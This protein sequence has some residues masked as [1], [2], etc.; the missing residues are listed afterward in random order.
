[1]SQFQQVGEGDN[2]GERRETEAVFR[3][4]V[5]QE[6]PR[7]LLVRQ[8]PARLPR[9]DAPVSGRDHV[10]AV[11]GVPRQLHPQAD[12]EAQRGGG[13]R[14]EET[15]SSTVE[16]DRLE[17]SPGGGGRVPVPQRESQGRFESA[18][19]HS[20]YERRGAAVDRCVSAVS[21]AVRQGWW[22]LIVT[23]GVSQVTCRTGSRVQTNG[24]F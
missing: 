22:F 13:F 15:P 6:V 3:R 21:A 23:L 5:R 4:Q 18:I 20:G 8:L 24:S 17:T 12:V 11:R 2:G 1:V 14:P 7:D 10:E 19:D 9:Q 16:S